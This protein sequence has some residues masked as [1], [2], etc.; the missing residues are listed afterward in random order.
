MGNKQ[1]NIYKQFKKEKN[2]CTNKQQAKKTMNTLCKY[3]DNNIENFT[4]FLAHVIPTC[5]NLNIK[6]HNIQ[7]GKI[8]QHGA[9]GYTFLV[10][11]DEKNPYVIKIVFLDNT[12]K[13]NT[14]LYN[15][16]ISEINIHSSLMKSNLYSKYLYK[17]IWFYI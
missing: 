15:H 10:H 12:D 7:R 13:K 1:S 4:Y 9:F 17:I 5:N 2:N 8:L 14:S 3:T 11:T 16:N 6:L